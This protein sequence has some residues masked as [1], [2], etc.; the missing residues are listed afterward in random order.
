MLARLRLQPGKVVREGTELANEKALRKQSMVIDDIRI[1]QRHIAGV[2]FLLPQSH[3]PANYRAR[4][5]PRET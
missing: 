2:G 5:F 1:E 4:E 3:N